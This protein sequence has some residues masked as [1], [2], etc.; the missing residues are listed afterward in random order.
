M[1]EKNYRKLYPL[2]I[3]YCRTIEETLKDAD[4]C[5]IFTEWDEIRNFDIAKFGELMRN[6][7]VSMDQ[8]KT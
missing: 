2:Q 1:G 6:P 4:I 7:I 5:F 8:P 3:Q